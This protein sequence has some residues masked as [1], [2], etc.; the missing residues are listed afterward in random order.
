M[1]D[2]CRVPGPEGF[3]WSVTYAKQGDLGDSGH[4]IVFRKNRVWKVDATRDG[5]ILSTDQFE[6]YARFYFTHFTNKEI[7]RCSI[8]M[9]TRR[10]NIL[11]LAC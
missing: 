3:D 1:F 5:Q 10:M 8:F 2:C 6:K 11:E 9:I 7:D 4:I